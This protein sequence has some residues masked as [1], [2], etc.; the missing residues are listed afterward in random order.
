[1]FDNAIRLPELRDKAVGSG[2]FAVAFF[3]CIVAGVGMSLE[4]LEK[5][6]EVSSKFLRA[7][8]K[9]FWDAS[10]ESVG[11]S[12]ESKDFHYHLE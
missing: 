4:Q 6:K 11:G 3:G 5:K 9:E 1:M 8:G 10:G 2:S 7:H 12:I